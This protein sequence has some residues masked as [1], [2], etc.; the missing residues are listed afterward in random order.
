MSENGE[1]VAAGGSA[2]TS[3]AGKEFPAVE[4]MK[5]VDA[6]PEDPAVAWARRAFERVLA[7]WAWDVMALKRSGR[8]APGWPDDARP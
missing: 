2:T 1:R 3:G 6:A 4:P 5:T 7:G 8:A